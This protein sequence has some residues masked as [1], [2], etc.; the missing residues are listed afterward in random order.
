MDLLSEK[1]I[2]ILLC[3]ILFLYLYVPN[4]FKGV[5]YVCI[6]TPNKNLKG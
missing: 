4:I 6:K 3:F 5:V 2:H 1:K